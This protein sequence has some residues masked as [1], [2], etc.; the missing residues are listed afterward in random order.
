MPEFEL[1][2]LP[3]VLSTASKKR[4]D[5]KRQKIAGAELAFTRPTEEAEEI[6]DDSARQPRSDVDNALAPEVAPAVVAD[7]PPA[8]ARASSDTPTPTDDSA[9]VVT[10]LPPAWARPL[11][12]TPTPTSSD[13]FASAVASSP[14]AWARPVSDPPSP[15]SDSVP[16][17][18]GLPTPLP[19]TPSP[20]SFPDGYAVV[21][22]DLPAAWTQPLSDTPFPI[23]FLNDSSVGARDEDVEEDVHVESEGGGVEEEER[24]DYDPAIRLD[25][26]GRIIE[27]DE[28]QQ[29]PKIIPEEPEEDLVGWGFKADPAISSDP[30]VP[31]IEARE[32]QEPPKIVRLES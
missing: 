9:S 3:P 25:T 30:Y 32:P 26:Y 6:P 4:K 10:S 17:V 1:G 28:P 7:F 22:A 16:T 23:T 14:P 27:Q 8:W 11:S 31:G 18:A 19:D 5:L 12:D 24:L 20:P 2:A 29:P 13:D 21:V 15:T